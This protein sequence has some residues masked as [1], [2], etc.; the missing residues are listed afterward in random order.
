MVSYERGA[1]LQFGMETTED[2][3]FEVQ[4]YFMTIFHVVQSIT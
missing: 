4:K 2:L 1:K 3:Y